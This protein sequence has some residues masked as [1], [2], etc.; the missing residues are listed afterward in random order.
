MENPSGKM[1]DI[2]DKNK[3]DVPVNIV[4]NGLPI[5]SPQY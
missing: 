3:N 4:I 2:Q 1:L 5:T